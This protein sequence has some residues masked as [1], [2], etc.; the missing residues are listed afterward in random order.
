MVVPGRTGISAGNLCRSSVAVRFGVTISFTYWG[1][2][3]FTPFPSCLFV[4]FV[5]RIGY[6][7]SEAPGGKYSATGI[8]TTLGPSRDRAS[9]TVS[10]TSSGRS[11]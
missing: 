3:S 6:L 5:D 7:G 11:T 10:A 8:S 2:Y 4:P 1:L 9:R